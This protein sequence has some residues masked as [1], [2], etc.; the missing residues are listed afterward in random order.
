MAAIDAI[1]NGRQ[2][3][4][5]LYTQTDGNASIQVSMFDIGEHMGLDRDRA[6][7][8]AESLIGSGFVTVKTLSGGIGITDDGVA[9]ALRLG[10][11]TGAPAGDGPAGIGDGPL[12]GET[13]CRRIEQIVAVL[14]T[15]AGERS[16]CFES[17]TEL[18][19]DLKTIDAQMISP[20]PKTAIVRECFRSIQSIL[21][22]TGGA[23][24]IAVRVDRLLGEP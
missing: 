14:K 12:L 22:S 4:T 18:M 13:V 10:C 7:R 3:L 19:A 23:D 24:D 9:E 11:G 17:L 20:R 8:T 2:F 5:E 1:E 21:K 15:Q 16:W 6:S